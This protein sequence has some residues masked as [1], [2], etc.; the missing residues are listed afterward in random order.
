MVLIFILSAITANLFSSEI[1]LSRDI[2]R[3]MKGYGYTVFQGW[4]S[5]RFEVEII[6]VMRN[7][8][9]GNDLILARLSG[10]ILEKSGVIAGMSGS[11]VYIDGKL[12]GA[13]AYTWSFQKEPICG[14]T[15]IKMMLNERKNADPPLFGDNDNVKR[16]AMPVTLHGFHPEAREFLNEKFADTGFSFADSVGG[17]SLELPADPAFKA[18]DAVSVNL[19]DG[20]LSISVIGSVSFVSNNDMLIFGHPF[21]LAGNISL[22]VSKAYIY[23]V[24]P[25]STISFK[26]GAGS[27][28]SGATVFDGRSGVYVRL[29]KTASM[30]PF[31][32][33]I[34]T[35][36]GNHRYSFRVTPEKNY[37]SSLA[38][39]ALVSSVANHLGYF[40]D[41]TV[42]MRFSIDIQY[43]GKIHKVTNEIVY[44]Q[45]LS[46]YNIR[47][48]IM[49]LYGYFGLLQQNALTDINITKVDV[50]VIIE[51]GVNYYV[52]ENAITDKTFYSPGET[53]KINVILWQYKGTYITRRMEVDVPQN[54]SPG[55]YFVYIGSEPAVNSRIRGL[56]PHYYT[57]ET[58]ADLIDTANRRE[59]RNK[60]L[61]VFLHTESGF[62][63]G[64]NKLFGMPEYY[65]N[66]FNVQTASGKPLLFPRRV[67]NFV[68]MDSPVFGT[69]DFRVDIDGSNTR[70]G[71]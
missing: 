55:K 47:M 30:I 39:S 31:N 19:V 38:S 48:M 5:E 3:G 61:A 60:L 18:G 6:D 34:K 45:L 13:V 70:G 9:A 28:P 14:I 56:Y 22:P 16:I 42:T 54:L 33:N 7:A 35:H 50:D 68:F 51:R 11:P 36:S 21:D 65:M 52:V 43:N 44:S 20:D 67:E 12:I 2:K 15:P 25:T 32:V 66:M 37:L 29:D 53:M 1:L 49:D 46:L 4:D 64:K 10:N 17:A 27:K 40:D 71:E 57:I 69:F 24:I 59:Y 58:F 63:M 62:V 23:T 8:F 26:M 41:K